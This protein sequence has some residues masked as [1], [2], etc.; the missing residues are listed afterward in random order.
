MKKNIKII[1]NFLT[2]SQANEIE[3]TMSSN[4]FPWYYNDGVAFQN[5]VGNDDFYFTH[6]FYTNNIFQSNFLES[7]VFPILKK[8]QPKSLIRIKGNLYPQTKDIKNNSSHVDY[9]FS[10]L[11]AIYYV[12]S[13]NGFTIIND[14][15][16]IESVKNR[17][18]LFDPS[19]PH[20]ST[21][22]SDEK[23]RININFNYF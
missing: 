13:N 5:K 7:I 18:V 4:M 6:L 10:H 3:E 16:K 12:N 2:K 15:E 14:Q 11:G 22:C 1:D 20:K 19:V 9:K 8:I 23:I 17:L 21:H